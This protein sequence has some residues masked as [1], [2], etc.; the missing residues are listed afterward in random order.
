M[1][2]QF[3]VIC[4]HVNTTT[5]KCGH[6][7]LADTVWAFDALLTLPG[8]SVYLVPAVGYRVQLW[9]RSPFPPKKDSRT[10]NCRNPKSSHE[11]VNIK[12]RVTH[13]LTVAM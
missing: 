13:S 2:S 12:G 8:C 5:V 6:Q 3:N 9:D 1:V 11:I 7:R 4:T 10:L